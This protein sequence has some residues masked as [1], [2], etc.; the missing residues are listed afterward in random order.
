MLTAFFTVG[1]GATFFAGQNSASKQETALRIGEL[2]ARAY[3]VSQKKVENVSCPLYLGELCSDG[4]IT[5]G[6]GI[7]TE[8]LGRIVLPDDRSEFASSS[9][10]M[11]CGKSVLVEGRLILSRSDFREALK[12]CEIVFIN[13][14]SRFGAGPVF[15]YDGKAQ[16]YRM[17]KTDGYEIIMPQ[18]EVGGYQG[19]IKRTFY[20]PLKKKAYVVFEPDSTELDMSDP[21]PGYQMLVLSTCTSRKHFLDEI[22]GF[23]GSYPTTAIFTTKPSCMDT[24]S[25]I[26]MRFLYD[27][28]SGQQINEIVE[29]M[30]E[31]YVAVAWEN[32][33]KQVSPWRVMEN[34][35][36][37]EINNLPIK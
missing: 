5:I 18:K 32:V 6:L 34:L 37:V 16:P 33:K 3:D 9:K 22:A 20:G 31:E 1:C 13:S 28:F 14:H 8:D 26:F 29:G 30:N 35:Y 17:Q 15:L 36:A 12:E 4:K 24:R 27:V 7:G 2:I 21:L 11:I 23:R 25:R 19:V 10:Y